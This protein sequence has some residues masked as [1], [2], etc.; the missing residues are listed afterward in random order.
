MFSEF[1]KFWLAQIF[2]EYVSWVLATLYVKKKYFPLC[3]EIMNSV[4][5]NVNVLISRFGD[6][7]VGHKNRAL[8]VSTDLYRAEIVAKFKK[9]RMN[10]NALATAI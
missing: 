1:G 10:P 6:R 4:I 7:V 8:I 3:Y 5:P 9:N 2:G